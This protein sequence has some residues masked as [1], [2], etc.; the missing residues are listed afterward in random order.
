MKKYISDWRIKENIVLGDKYFLLKL[1]LEKS[2]PKIL[3]GQFVQV[4]MQDSENTFLRR[5]ISVHY[6][7]NNELWLLIKI[8]G[9]G[10]YKLSKIQPN[11]YLNLIYPLGNGFSVP[12]DFSKNKKIFLIGGGIGIAPLLYLGYYLKNLNFDPIFLL[13]LKTENDL[14]QLSEFRRHGTVYITTENGMLGEKGFVTDHSLLF[15]VNVNF[16]YACG[17]IPMMISVAK[18]AKKYNIQCEVSLENRMACGFGVCL[19]CIEKTKQGNICICKKGPV[20]NINKLKWQ[21]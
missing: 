19:C 16:I 9:K 20:I 15:T 21:I 14:L 3:P 18:Y 8:V 17:P 12:S 6:V 11:E 7:I 4:K 1:C 5:P 13:G 10:T 2:L